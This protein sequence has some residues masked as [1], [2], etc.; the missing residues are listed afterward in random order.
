MFDRPEGCNDKWPTIERVNHHLP[1]HPIYHQRI[2][3]ET[4]N[5]DQF[6]S[7]MSRSIS[8]EVSLADASAH[9]FLDYVAFCVRC[10]WSYDLMSCQRAR[11][12]NAS[13]N[14]H[15]SFGSGSDGSSGDPAVMAAGVCL[16]E[17]KQ[18]SLEPFESLWDGATQYILFECLDDQG[19]PQGK[20]VGRVLQRYRP[21]T[22]GASYVWSTL[23]VTDSYSEHWLRDEGQKVKFHH[24]C[25]NSLS[26]CKGKVGG[27]PIIHIQK[28]AF[29]RVD[30][31]GAC[32]KEWK[33]KCLDEEVPGAKGKKRRPLETYRVWRALYSTKVEARD[34]GRENGTPVVAGEGL[35]IPGLSA[36]TS[37]RTRMWENRM[38]QEDA[39]GEGDHMVRMRR[40]S[41]RGKT[42]REP[43]ALWEQSHAYQLVSC[44]GQAITMKNPGDGVKRCA[45]TWTYDLISCHVRKHVCR[46]SRSMTTVVLVPLPP[47]AD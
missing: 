40:R 34:R 47:S 12:Q 36:T 6:Y 42:L 41:F 5:S 27:K 4:L 2:K 35:G 1:L 31:V 32:L 14:D 44:D 22:N 24:V 45:M 18:C 30:E 39:D 43:G 3:I 16:R 46:I 21:D 10:A 7:Y 26:T 15:C 38:R 9:C 28:M 37:R 33:V 19:A 25:R 23:A 8:F 13:V 20:A 17:T 11:V 29:M